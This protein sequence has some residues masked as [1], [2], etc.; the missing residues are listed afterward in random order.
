MPNSRLAA[1][2]KKLSAGFKAVSDPFGD[3]YFNP[4]EYEKLRLEEEPR[5]VE[6]AFRAAKE[7]AA[8]QERTKVE[9]KFKEP[10][11]VRR[12]WE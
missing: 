2:V 4:V 10:V 1:F 8:Q 9:V 11:R 7:K 6:E 5:V 12:D 3:D